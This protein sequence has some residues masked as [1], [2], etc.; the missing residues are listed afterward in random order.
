M[1]E[2]ATI[3]QKIGEDI[4]N[5][6]NG[7][8]DG[9][10]WV[11]RDKNETT[12][13]LGLISK[14]NHHIPE[15]LEYAWFH[16]SVERFI[17]DLLSA[18]DCSNESYET[19]TRFINSVI[20][21]GTGGAEYTIFYHTPFDRITGADSYRPAIFTVT[22]GV[23]NIILHHN[24]PTY[25]CRARDEYI[26]NGYGDR[27]FFRTY[28]LSEKQLSDGKFW[29]LNGEVFDSSGEPEL[30]TLKIVTNNEADVTSVTF[31]IDDYVTGEM[32]DGH[33]IIT[34]I[35]PDRVKNIDINTDDF[36]FAELGDAIFKRKRELV[37]NTGYKYPDQA[38]VIDV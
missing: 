10:L 20:K 28:R 27:E 32:N 2:E 24:V 22:P 16:N 17:Q 19:I 11:W 8:F 30:F 23:S 26:K 37:I 15:G 25:D 34:L 1:L 36:S 13:V 12:G 9:P 5:V 4:T 14:L 38:E 31:P 7:N 18:S 33:L 3:R 6:T 35:N 29:F 21:V